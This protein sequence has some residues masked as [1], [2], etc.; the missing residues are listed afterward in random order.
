MPIQI[1]NEIY[2]EE[3]EFLKSEATASKNA[4]LKKTEEAEALKQDSEAKAIRFISLS[5]NEKQNTS[6]LIKNGVP[7]CP[8]CIVRSNDFHDMSPQSGD[9]DHDYFS[10]KSCGLQIEIEI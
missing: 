7:Q 10:C 9:N 3:I 2:K 4:Y 5:E 1:L 6:S 8:R